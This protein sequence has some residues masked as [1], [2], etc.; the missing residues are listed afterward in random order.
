[1]KM[2]LLFLAA[3]L[4]AE[5]SD[6]QWTGKGAYRLLPEVLPEDIGKRKSDVMPADISVDFAQKLKEL[7]PVELNSFDQRID[8]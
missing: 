4:L 5:E 3:L 2:A 1:M 7:L 6:T 8:H